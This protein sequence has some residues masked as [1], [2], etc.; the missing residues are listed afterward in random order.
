MIGHYDYLKGNKLSW[1]ETLIAM[2]GYYGTFCGRWHSNEF[3]KETALKIEGMTEE[4]CKEKIIQ[5]EHE[6]DAELAYWQAMQ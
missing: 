3:W 2:C 6:A 1:K 5:I 4:Q